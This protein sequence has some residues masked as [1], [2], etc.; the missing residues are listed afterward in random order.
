MIETESNHYITVTKSL[1]SV[2]SLKMASPARRSCKTPFTLDI[3][4]E[5]KHSKF[6]FRK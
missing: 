4:L 3:Y 1:L 6:F 5:I 2:K